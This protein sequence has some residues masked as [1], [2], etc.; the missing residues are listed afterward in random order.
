MHNERAAMMFYLG[1]L[2]MLLGVLLWAY[3]QFTLTYVCVS[4][5][6]CVSLGCMSVPFL[7]LTHCRPHL[8]S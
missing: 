7:I 2:L 4:I 8:H 1:T 3:A 6:S 5:S